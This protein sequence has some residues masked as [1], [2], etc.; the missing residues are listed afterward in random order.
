MDPVLPRL[1]ARAT[2]SIDAD[3]GF[4]RPAIATSKLRPLLP[5]P[6]KTRVWRNE[7]SNSSESNPI[8]HS[9]TL[10]V[11]RRKCRHICHHMPSPAITLVGYAR[12]SRRSRDIARKALAAVPSQFQVAIQPRRNGLRRH[13]N[14]YR[15]H[16]AGFKANPARSASND[17]VQSGSAQALG[18]RAS[19]RHSR[20]SSRTVP[21]EVSKRGAG[22]TPA[23]QG[24][25]AH[26]Q[27]HSA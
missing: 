25:A 3:G 20:N 23:L 19:A 8:H 11:F 22:G 17:T 9:I 10:A 7:T 12:R 26:R 21:V 18:A 5:L 15:T 27:R 14:I 2:G 24:F 6:L 4:R 13:K 1:R 16:G